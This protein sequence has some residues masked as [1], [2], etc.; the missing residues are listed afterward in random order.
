MFPKH[1]LAVMHVEEGSLKRIFTVANQ[2]TPISLNRQEFA[3]T[4]SGIK[5]ANSINVG[6]VL[7]AYGFDGI[8]RRAT[9]NNL[10]QQKK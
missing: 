1:D 10:R 8:E 9:V 4:Q 2:R 6:D 7:Y 3:L 5:I